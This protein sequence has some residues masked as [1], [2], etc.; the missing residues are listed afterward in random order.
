M[1]A[2]AGLAVGAGL[3]G[4][5]WE[6][7]VYDLEHG[8]RRLKGRA[9][10]NN[11]RNAIKS[12]LQECSAA[13]AEV[14]YYA[15]RLTERSRGWPIHDDRLLNES[16]IPSL[17]ARE[18][19][20]VASQR[21]AARLRGHSLMRPWVVEWVPV[22]G[23]DNPDAFLVASD[24]SLWQ[25]NDSATWGCATGSGWRASGLALDRVA[26]N[27]NPTAAEAVGIANAIAMYPPGCDITVMSDSQDAVSA[28][29]ELINGVPFAT[30][31]A[32]YSDPGLRCGFLPPGDPDTDGTPLHL[33]RSAL[34]QAGTVRVDWVRR[35]THPLQITA[36]DLAKR[37]QY[38]ERERAAALGSER[39]EQ[40]VSA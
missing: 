13:G 14:R 8:H 21:A 12:A 11:R 3:A 32:A 1:G 27:L 26:G 23:L 6:A 25:H 38:S 18:F 2:L 7:D 5:E 29:K 37:M 4:W 10:G 16:T 30:V 33:I 22:A 36:H 35:D 28:T 40:Q 24:A 19:L 9:E 17:A 34:S 39:P 31:Y 15:A 20:L